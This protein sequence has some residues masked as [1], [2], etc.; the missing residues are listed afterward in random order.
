[1]LPIINDKITGQCIF[2]DPV[3]NKLEVRLTRLHTQ[4]ILA[5]VKTDLFL[6]TSYVI[7]VSKE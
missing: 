6:S 4:G 5:Y 3:F 1:M 2:L 7:S